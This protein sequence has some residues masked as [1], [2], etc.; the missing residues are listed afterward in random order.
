MSKFTKSKKIIVVL[1]LICTVFMLA[2]CGTNQTDANGN[3]IQNTNSTSAKIVGTILEG[4]H[5]ALSYVHVNNY[6]YAIILLTLLVKVVTTPLNVKQQKSM[7]A[8]QAMQPKMQEISKKY[9]SNPQKKQEEVAKLYSD[10]KISPLS[11][12]LP[13][14]IQMPILFVL[15]YGMRNWAPADSI[16]TAGHYS[17]FWIS[18]LSETVKNTPYQWVLPIGCALVTLVQQ[19][20]STTNRQDMT[21]K[22][23]LIMMP[24]MFLFMTK[25]FP[26]ALA[27]Y[28]L[29]Y[30]FFTMIQTTWLNYKMKAGFFAPKEEK[31]KS[32]ITMA[33]EY[34]DKEQAKKDKTQQ[35][36][37]EK[38]TRHEVTHNQSQKN[39]EIQANSEG[40]KDR[41][42]KDKPWQ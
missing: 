30:G 1:L 39:T 38:H 23:M 4:L 27:I 35:K 28:W 25:Q 31:P 21:Q 15:F 8:M 12:C 40:H 6:V 36:H 3:Y 37:E 10:A 42:A 32:K 18:N 11:G 29:F 22:M 34:Y 13:I 14:L 20:M 7:K 17:F 19:Y 26:A 16:I 24:A 2:A 9:E 33:A 5:V 41:E